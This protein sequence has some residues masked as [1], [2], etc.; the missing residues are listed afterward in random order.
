MFS[1]L[2]QKAVQIA[3]ENPNDFSLGLL[4]KRLKIGNIACSK[5]LDDL[6]KEGLISEYDPQRKGR[7]VLFNN[8]DK[9]AH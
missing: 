5:L 3:M 8:Y 7:R 4:Q 6:E 1:D 2:K 9:T